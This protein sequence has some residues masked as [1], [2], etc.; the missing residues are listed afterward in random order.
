MATVLAPAAAID[1]R[2][3]WLDRRRIQWPEVEAGAAFKLYYSGRGAIVASA[4]ARV[5]GADG[6]LTLTVDGHVL[7]AA[8]AERFKFVAGGARLKVRSADLPRLPA[9]HRQQLVLVRENDVGEVL[10]ATALQVA[11][12]LDD[13]YAGADG[14]ELGA[15]V[16]AGATHFALWAPTARAVWLCSYVSGSSPASAIERMGLDP[17]SG[18]WSLRRRGQLGS[19]Y[20]A[21]VVD[22]FA[23]G[24]GWVRNRVTDPYSL[25]LTTDSQRSYMA[26]L[27]AAALKPAGWD[28]TP[29]PDRVQAATDM[30]IYELQVRDFSANDA[31]VSPAHRGKYLAFTE[32]AS[33]GMQHLKR[34]AG[35]GVTDVHLL[36]VF[37]I[38]SVPE[39]GCTTPTVPAGRSRQRRPAGCGG[40]SGRHRLLQLG[41]RPLALQRA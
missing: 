18:V 30:V 19:R 26:D 12:A 37:D 13:L 4:G 11:G 7:P 39:S 17:Q 40:A 15:K 9:L 10:A 3:Y 20:Y 36:P 27:N 21:Y 6:A 29:R 38:A 34:L 33:R 35:A 41:L 22:V 32:S 23:R 16:R 14:A 24:I 28:S 5:V 1:A 31:T 25:S 8:L 2:A